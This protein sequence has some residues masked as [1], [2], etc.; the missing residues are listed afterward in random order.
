MHHSVC[1]PRLWFLST[2]ETFLSGFHSSFDSSLSTALPVFHVQRKSTICTEI[3]IN[4]V[5][6]L[7][8]RIDLGLQ[9]SDCLITETQKFRN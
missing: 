4:P 5:H 9:I 7:R 3:V 8:L 2:S 6:V 1:N